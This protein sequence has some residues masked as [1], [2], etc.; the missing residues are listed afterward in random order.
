[1]KIEKVIS[2]IKEVLKDFGEDEFEKLYS[3]IKK[4]ERV[5]VCGAGRSGLIGRCFAMRLRHLGKESY[6][7]GETICPPI[8]EKDLLIIISY[9][10]EKKSI[11]PICEIA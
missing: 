4:S 8:K 5:F 2:E 7:V 10:G 1:M 9:S 6:V 11:I 3:L